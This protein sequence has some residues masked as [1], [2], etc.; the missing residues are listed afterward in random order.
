MLSEDIE[1]AVSYEEAG[2]DFWTPVFQK[3]A[4]EAK[5]LEDKINENN[6]NKQD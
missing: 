6:P 5:A 3:W 4:L 1:D 2:S